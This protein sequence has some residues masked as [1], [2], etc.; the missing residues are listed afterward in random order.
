MKKMYYA[1]VEGKVDFEEKVLNAPILCLSHK[2]G[3]FSV[4]DETMKDLI[5]K[6]NP[7]KDSSTKFV[8]LGYDQASDSTLL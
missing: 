2:E 5:N 3:I 7:L 1:R 4:Y 6:Q 8:N